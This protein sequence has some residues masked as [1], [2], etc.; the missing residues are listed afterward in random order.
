MWA[1]ELMGCCCCGVSEYLRTDWERRAP[2]RRDRRG[3]LRAALGKN[4]QP[5]LHIPS[6][7]DLLD[8]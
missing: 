2:H 4:Y 1:Y 3:S 5:S 8:L 6:Y 7:R